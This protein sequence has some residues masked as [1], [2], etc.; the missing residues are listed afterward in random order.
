M[1]TKTLSVDEEAYRRL[2]GARLHPQESFS[3]VIKRAHWGEGKRRCGD[4]LVRAGGVLSEAQLARLER[5]QREDHPPGD[6]W[7][8]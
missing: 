4:L 6:K 5:A 1:G 8:P 7:N 2:V 3:K